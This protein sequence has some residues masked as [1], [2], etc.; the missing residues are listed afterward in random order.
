MFLGKN[1]LKKFKKTLD[2]IR[3]NVYNYKRKDEE[4]KKK[5]RGRKMKEKILRKAEE[6]TGVKPKRW[7]GQNGIV[8]YYFNYSSNKTIYF[9]FREDGTIE[10][11]ANRPGATT[12]IYNT[13]EEF[14]LEVI[15]KKG[16]WSRWSN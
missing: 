1:L 8:R 3:A 10:A 13:L 12:E 4:I 5:E 14:G 15:A 6:I 16:N 7:E 11:K 2:N 9:C